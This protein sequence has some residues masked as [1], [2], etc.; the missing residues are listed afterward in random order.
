MTNQFDVNKLNS[1][2][3]KAT[4]AIS[5]NSE[6]QKNKE[7]QELK[8]K[9]LKA[10]SNLTLAEPE[11][12]ISKRNY[13]TYVS[14]KSGYDEII[15]KEL[16]AKANEIIKE[17]EKLYKDETD[18]IKTQINSYES[19]LINY[20][21]VVDLDEKYKKDNA[22][23]YKEYKEDANDILTNE[24]KTYYEDQKNTQL[25]NYYYYIFLTIYIIVLLCLTYFSL[26]YPSQR[27][28]KTKI[29]I[30]ILF[31]FLPFILDWL[32]KKIL[33]LFHL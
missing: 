7:K 31:I 9:Y 22:E 29:A 15:E 33:N 27:E 3:D 28:F 1:F 20:R 26:F 25:N 2:L 4:K 8:Y 11:Y 12:E 14:G 5:C 17:F 19:I 10:K 13:Y 23:L 30:I 21:N 24:R 32:I 6:C 16:N 18:R